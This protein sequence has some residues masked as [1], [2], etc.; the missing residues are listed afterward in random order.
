MMGFIGTS[1]TI[2]LN[3]IQYSAIADLNNLQFILAH[4]L[5]FSVSTSRLLVR[6]LNTETVTSNYY[7][8]F[9]SILLQ[10]LCPPLS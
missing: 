8:V 10:S 4:A 1:V 2:S 6:D 5:G 7:E 9:L 3:Y